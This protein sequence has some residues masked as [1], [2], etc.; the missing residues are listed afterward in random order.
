MFAFEM[1]PQRQHKFIE[2][3]NAFRNNF[4]EVTSARVINF[5]LK[6]RHL[7]LLWN[8]RVL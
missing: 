5:G 2:W 6:F 1:L 3:V 8:L 4:L 7:S